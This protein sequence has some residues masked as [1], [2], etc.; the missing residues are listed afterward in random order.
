ME[1][2]HIANIV[3]AG[4]PNVTAPKVDVGDSFMILPASDAHAVL[5]FLKEDDDLYFDSLMC[6]SGADTGREL[7]VVYSL[8]S[9]TH[10][11]KASVKVVLHRENPS[12]DTVSDIW[13][14]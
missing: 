7:W 13:A 9:L 3:K 12:C 11:H 4:W 5:K 2:E 1:F 10:F 6:L 14:M 8:H